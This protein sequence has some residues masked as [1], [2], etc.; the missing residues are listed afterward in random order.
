MQRYYRLDL[1][2]VWRGHMTFRRLRA[3][4]EHLPADSAL[5]Y[6]I[7]DVDENRRGWSLSDLL[8]GSAVDALNRLQWLYSEVHRDPKKAPRQAPHP[9][10]V[11][12]TALEKPEDIPLV[13]PHQLGGF[14]NEDLEVA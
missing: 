8:L 1:A 14:I 7:A 13:S 2:D 10:S 4:I 3:L 5:F 12:P 9:E 6:S 11:L